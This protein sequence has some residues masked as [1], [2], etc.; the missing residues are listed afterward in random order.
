VHQGDVVVAAYDVSEGR[1][2]LLYALDL[3]GVGQR[4]AQVLQLLVGRARGDQQAL[5]IAGR[6][7]ADDARAGDGGVADRDDILELGLE[8][9]TPVVCK[10]FVRLLSSRAAAAAA[11]A[12][13]LAVHVQA[14]A[15]VCR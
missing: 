12:V 14:R 1:Q 15:C 3:D 11:R 10:L 4:V 2:P 9:A 13:G 5:A 7:A 6:Q 8:D